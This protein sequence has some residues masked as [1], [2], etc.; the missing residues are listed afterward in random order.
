MKKLYPEI[1]PFETG[2]LPLDDQ[3]ELYYECC[4]NRDGKPALFLHGGPGAGTGPMHRRFF[5]PEKYFIILYHQRGA[6]KSTPS[7]CL[8]NNTSAHLVADIEY[9]RHHLNVEKWLVFGGSWGST[10]GLLYAESHPAHVTELILRGIFMLRAKEIDW[11]FKCGLPDIYPDLY[12][13]LVSF[14]PEN[15][16]QDIPA[17]YYEILT[18]DYDTDFKDRAARLW[19]QYE[20]GAIAIHPE[21]GFLKELDKPE[22]VRALASIET[23]YYLNRGFQEHDDQ[24]LRDIGR[25]QHIPTVIVH[26][27]QD[28]ICA[29]SAAYDL[30]KAHGSAELY[31]IDGAGHSV[32]EERIINCLI[33]ATDK[34]LLS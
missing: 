8:V 12:E 17:S 33:T 1:E 10:L 18:G 2:F 14:L 27:R 20:I 3:H 16:R 13:E 29:P 11:I 5:D 6:G 31:I 15:K 34:F 23:H 21:A 25:I 28:A 32:M 22:F 26:G 19:C 24:I 4:G 30:A 9:L 7:A